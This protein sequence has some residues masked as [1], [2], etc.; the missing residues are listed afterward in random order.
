MQSTGDH[1]S[2]VCVVSVVIILAATWVAAAED[3]VISIPPSRR[4]KT[5]P[6]ATD[7][8]DVRTGLD[9]EQYHW[10]VTRN[11]EL[12]SGVSDVD[13]PDELSRYNEFDVTIKERRRRQKRNLSGDDVARSALNASAL[14]RGRLTSNED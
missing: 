7:N 2:L 8:N 10:V 13:D 3:A 11:G 6:S 12:A 1:V 4:S 5:N 9:K 14:Q